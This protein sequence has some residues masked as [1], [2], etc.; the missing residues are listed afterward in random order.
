MMFNFLLA[1]A[2][3]AVSVQGMRL[4]GK[5]SIL[6]GEQSEEEGQASVSE[7]N[8]NASSGILPSK[9]NSM[10]RP[11]LSHRMSITQGQAA[12]AAGWLRPTMMKADNL[13]TQP[14]RRSARAGRVGVPYM[15]ATSPELASADQP[16][17]AERLA[18]RQIGEKVRS[19]GLFPLTVGFGTCLSN[20]PEGS[21][22]TA[23]KE[24]YHLFDTAQRYGNEVQVGEAIASSIKKGTLKR[25]DVWVTTKVW[26]DNMEYG[27][28]IESVRISARKLA[29]KAGLPAGGQPIE[30]GIDLVIL[31]W[32]GDFLAKGPEANMAFNKGLRKESWEALEMLKKNEEVK[33][34]GLANFGE[35]HLKELLTFAKVK[36]AVNQFEI[37][38]YNQRAKLVKL[39]Q[40]EGIAVNAYSPIGGK[41]NDKQVTD[42]LLK[43]PVLKKIADKYKKTIPQVILRWHLQR[44]ITPIPK[45]SSQKRIQENYD[46]FGFQLDDTDMGEIAKLE[47]GQFAILDADTLA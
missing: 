24:G 33:Q 28:T 47:R 15:L 11:A 42:E 34:I 40:D 2:L 8:V 19:G 1:W 18:A 43:D 3:L 41:G 5:K 39:C 37:H 38:P 46:V 17:M 21:V 25:E 22:K 36:P 27:K 7:I 23:I 44:G 16:S 10:G 29:G 9:G 45:A 20:D 32:P 12:P 31:H 6:E 35:R 14:T 30:G 13:G 26:C 4:Q